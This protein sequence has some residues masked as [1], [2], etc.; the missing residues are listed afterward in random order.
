MMPIVLVI[1]YKKLYKAPPQGSVLVEAS[2]VVKRLFA[3]G[4]WKRCWRGGD[5]FWSR[6]KPT[7]IREA[8]GGEIDSRKVFW[9]DKFVDELRQSFDA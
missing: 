4:G 8:E 5:D 2:A 1:A 7:Y 3:N 6:A 9:D